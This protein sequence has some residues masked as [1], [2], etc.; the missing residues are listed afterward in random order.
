[1]SLVFRAFG[2]L[3]ILLAVFFSSQ[4]VW[5]RVQ[6][7]SDSGSFVFWTILAVSCLVA[8]IGYLLKARW[9]VALG[10]APAML[11][12]AF[13]SLTVLVGGWIWGPRAATTMNLLVFGG[14][15]LALLQLVGLVL[16]M[17]RT[18][19]GPEQQARANNTAP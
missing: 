10:A 19:R 17:F 16:M 1:M 11:L 15:G 6:E 3:N 4:I 8:G 13:I 2:I 18:R 5:N 12:A 14:F 7:S 9:V